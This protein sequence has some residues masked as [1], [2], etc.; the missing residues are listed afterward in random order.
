MALGVFL[1]WINLK[2]YSFVLMMMNTDTWGRSGWMAWKADV[3]VLWAGR[4]ILVLAIACL[5]GAVIGHRTLTLTAAAAA[6][7][8]LAY[9]LIDFLNSDAHAVANPGIG[10]YLAMVGA[11]ATGIASLRWNA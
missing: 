5:L 2:P 10:L 4:P 8:L 7:L 1:P 11:I 6:I 9:N 3:F